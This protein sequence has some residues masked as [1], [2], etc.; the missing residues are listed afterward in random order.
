MSEAQ[1]PVPNQPLVADPAPLGLAG[2]ALTTFV[3]SVHAANW[4]PDLIWVG[5]ALFY[6]GLAQFMAGMNE[7]RN[8]NTFGATAF[9]SYGAFWA[10]LATFIVLDL[11]HAIPAALNVDNALGWFFAAFVIFNTYMMMW[12][13]L[14]NKAVFAVF[15][16]LEVTE[17][18]VCI[19]YFL[20]G[21]GHVFGTDLLH[22]GGYVGVLTAACAWYASAA[23][24]ANSITPNPLLPVGTPLWHPGAA[25]STLS[26][27]AH[28]GGGYSA[29]VPQA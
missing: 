5:L 13:S 15:F 2:F 16:T 7:F 26:A 14:L 3:L 10:S 19:G 23:G 8:K 28:R 1:A 24:V 6:G 11:A 29:P 25:L 17:I 21:S 12:S 20:A 4:A 22:V 27:R 9:S 18:L